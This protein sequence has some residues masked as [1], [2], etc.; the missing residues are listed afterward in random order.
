MNNFVPA[1]EHMGL[2]D[3]ALHQFQVGNGG[4]AAQTGRTSLTCKA[5]RCYPELQERQLAVYFLN[6]M[7]VG[8]VLRYSS[9]RPL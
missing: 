9:K 2:G 5:G 8:A 4:I 6:G 3:E 1:G 7:E